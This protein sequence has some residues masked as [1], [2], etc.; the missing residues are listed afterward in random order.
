MEAD[1]SAVDTGASAV[2]AATPATSM[3]TDLPPH[4]AAVAQ[5]IASGLADKRTPMT[6]HEAAAYMTYA[7]EVGP[8]KAGKVFNRHPSQ[9]YKLKQRAVEQEGSFKAKPSSGGAKSGPKA[10]LFPVGHRLSEK[11]HDE[12]IKMPGSTKKIAES[13]EAVGGRTPS[14]WT[15]GRE[16]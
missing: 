12:N 15:V 3:D 14:R 11:F 2:D 9:V 8:T 5:A 7:A 4:E 16:R 6:V 10:R 13:S 1:T